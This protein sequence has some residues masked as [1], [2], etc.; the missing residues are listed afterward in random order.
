MRMNGVSVQ[1]QRLEMVTAVDRGVRV[2]DICQVYGVSRETFYKWRRRWLKQGLEG[3]ADRSSR[4]L[5]PA[6]MVAASLERKIVEMRTAHRRWGPR[7][8]AAELRREGIC[9]PARSTIGTI[10]HRNGL[11]DDTRS[12]EPPA[13]QITRFERARANELWQMDATDFD[14]ADGTKVQIVTC[15]DDHSRL[16]PGLYPTLALTT[17]ATIAAFDTAG[18]NGYG[19]PYSVLSDNGTEFTSRMTGGVGPFERHLWQLG[20]PTLNGRPYHPQTQ[21]KV[22]RFHATIHQWLDD[23]QA[24]HGP[25][26]DLATLDGA[27][28][29]F[30]IDYNTNRPHQAFDDDRIPQDVFNA[31]DKAA[32]D[33]E[34]TAHLRKRTTVRHTAYN[35]N[36]SYADWTIGV[37]MAWANTIV[38]I[39]DYGSHIDLHH[40]DGT[41]IRTVKPDYTRSYLGTGKRRGRPPKR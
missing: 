18:C 11:V 12:G 23:W 27:L 19:L 15:V 6:G 26:V 37:G 24:E 39:T 1:Q 16:C 4:P 5:Q 36:L 7:R 25:I 41:L 35:G 9:P 40:P 29:L 38:V 22:E 33:P 3:L 32:P 31:A 28:E 8:I 21:G 13:E 10:L 14:L 30:R 20:I 17:E 34:G 2:T